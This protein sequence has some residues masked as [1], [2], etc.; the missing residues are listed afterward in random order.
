MDIEELSK[1]QIVLLTLLI[2]FV[3]SIATGIVT[4]SLMQQAPP[5]IAQSV[6]RVIERTVEKITPQKESQGASAASVITREKTVVVKESDLIPDAVGQALPSVVRLYS[7]AEEGS[8]FIGLG[9][10]VG[11]NG[12]LITDTA[13]LLERGSAAV[14][15]PDGSRVTALVTARDDATGLATLAAATTTD[16]GAINWRSATLGNAPGLGAS[17][18]LLS[19][20]G[21]A[22]IASGIVTAALSGEPQIIETDIA[23]DSI[24]PGSPIIDTNGSV[25]GVSTGISRA[26]Q[27]SGFVR[28]TIPSR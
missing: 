7:S 22:H 21:K 12:V 19:G 9:I 13:A 17:V 10:V 6:N 14:A 15:L 4:V 25:V 1:S 18:I 11:K 26:S 28:A 2:S 5:V 3:T 16:K 20:K 27:V 8:T 23:P 24:I